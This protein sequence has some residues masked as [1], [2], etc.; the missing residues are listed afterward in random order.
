MNSSEQ[1]NIP[2]PDTGKPEITMA[3][4]IDIVF[5][6][7]IFFMVT[8]VFPEDDGLMISIPASTHAA[9]LS[10]ENILL[11]ID[12][13]GQVYY[14]NSAVTLDDVKRIVSDELA[15]RPDAPVI[16]HADKLTTTESLINVIDVSK[17]AGAK[18][19]A[20][21]TDEKPIE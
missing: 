2:L 7:L 17:S 15:M 14:K 12:K 18:G 16:L 20:I 8:T 21:A 4:L 1:L 19:L 5:L 11:K 6:L 13:T 9:E 10:D 3:P